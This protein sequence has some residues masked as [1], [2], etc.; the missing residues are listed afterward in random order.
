M[1]IFKLD[2][3]LGLLVLGGNTAVLEVR[4]HLGL[5]VVGEDTLLVV[6]E[7]LRHVKLSVDGTVHEQV[8]HHLELARLAIGTTNE[9]ACLRLG[10]WLAFLIVTASAAFSACEV[11]S[12]LLRDEIPILGQETMEERPSTIATFIKIVAHHEI[13]W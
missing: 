4:A 5:V 9:V 2:H 13:L 7:H 10:L 6:A 11:W 8:L 3:L 12:T 1:H